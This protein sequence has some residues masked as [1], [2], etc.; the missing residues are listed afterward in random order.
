MTI[1]EKVIEIV[2]YIIVPTAMFVISPALGKYLDHL[3]LK[4]D[5][6]FVQNIIL[7]SV[8]ILV[9]LMGVSLILWTIFLFKRYGKGTP[10]PTI[11][12]KELVIRGP[13][14]IVRN[15]MVL[16]GAM[17]LFGEVVVYYSLFLLLISILYVIITYFNAMFVEEPE[18]KKRFGQPYEQYLKEV[19][20]FL[21]NIFR[22]PK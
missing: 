10:N 11:P 1:R 15:P 9:S 18:L 8:G 7:M 16:G 19:P 6:L 2:T 17:I 13:Y 4:T 14:K 20:R 22:N 12:P 21:P 3:V 5:Y